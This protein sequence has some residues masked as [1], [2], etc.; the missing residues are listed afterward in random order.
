MT[1]DTTRQAWVTSIP[2][3]CLPDASYARTGDPFAERADG[4]HWIKYAYGDVPKLLGGSGAYLED[5]RQNITPNPSVKLLLASGD[6]RKAGRPARGQ[7]AARP[8]SSARPSRTPRA[9]P[10]ERI[11]PTATRSR[12][13]PEKP[14]TA[15]RCHVLG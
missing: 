7:C 6:V 1:A 11:C 14:K 4:K 15:G 8:S 5:Q 12:T 9:A 3:R 10:T 13:L 2:A